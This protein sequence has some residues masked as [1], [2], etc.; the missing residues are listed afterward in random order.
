MCP[1]ARHAP[2]MAG[3]ARAHSEPC[4]PVTPPPPPPLISAGG[5]GTESYS[6]EAGG[7]YN[8]RTRLESGD[9]RDG[10]GR[11]G[12][13]AHE[14]G[15]ELITCFSV[16][17]CVQW[18]PAVVCSSGSAETQIFVCCLSCCGPVSTS[19]C[20]ILSCGDGSVLG[21]LWASFYPLSPVACLSLSRLC[22]LSRLYPVVPR[23]VA[24]SAVADPQ[25][26][27]HE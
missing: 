17:T 19:L 6:T 8:Y 12:R 22:P 2:A 5:S 1:R 14:G 26:A 9:R 11:D 18:C 24:V 15:N 3:R 7:P 20:P 13:E 10:T 4:M 27:C 21:P 25:S 23:S 16:P